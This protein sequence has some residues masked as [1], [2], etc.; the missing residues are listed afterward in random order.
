VHI[1]IKV[2]KLILYN[3]LFGSYAIL[4]MTCSQ[5]KQVINAEKEKIWD[6]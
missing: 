4:H 2:K 6:Q 1:F 5:K 3:N